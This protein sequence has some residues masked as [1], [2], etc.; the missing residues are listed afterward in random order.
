MKKYCVLCTR[1]FGTLK[2]T[3][4]GICE[5][6]PDVPERYIVSLKELKDETKKKIVNLK[7]KKKGVNH[8]LVFHKWILK[9]ITD[10]KKNP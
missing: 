3:K 8:E 4:D 5:T 6:H 7:M 2:E 9:E 10:T 1:W